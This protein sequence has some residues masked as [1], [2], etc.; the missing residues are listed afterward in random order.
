MI[1][2]ID[3]Y[4]MIFRVSSLYGDD[5]AG[6][7]SPI[8]DLRRDAS[9]GTQEK[10]IRVLKQFAAP[11]SVGFVAEYTLLALESA[12]E[13]PRTCSGVYNLVPHEPMWKSD[14][15]RYAIDAF[16]PDKHEAVITEGKLA[17]PR[18]EFSVLNNDKF[19]TTFGVQLP[20]VYQVFEKFAMLFDTPDAEEPALPP[21]SSPSPPSSPKPA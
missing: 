10:P 17:I 4:H 1:R 20:N 8:R 21:E 16:L 11:S 18:P 2:A 19:E 14:F 15:A 12:V 5:F 13:S 9:L 7:L 3:G 6:A